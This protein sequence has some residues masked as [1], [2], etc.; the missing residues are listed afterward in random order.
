MSGVN[1]ILLPIKYNDSFKN[2][3]VMLFML[4]KL[5]SLGHINSF[6]VSR[7]VTFNDYQKY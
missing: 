6:Y 2:F 5:I 7:V 3:I 4:P 1:S